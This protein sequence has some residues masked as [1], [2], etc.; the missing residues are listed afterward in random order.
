MVARFGVPSDL[1]SDCG[2]KITS[3]VWTQVFRSLGISPSTTTSFH[4]QSNGMIECFHRSLKTALRN[5][6]AGS[7]WFLHLPLVL[8]GLRSA[9]NGGHRVLRLRGCVRFLKSSWMVMSLRHLS[10]CRR[11][12]WL[13]LDSPA[14][15][16]HHVSPAQPAP[17]PPALLAAKYILVREEASISTLAPL[18]VV[19]IWSWNGGL[20]SSAFT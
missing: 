12:S 15:P 20:N 6:L 18:F 10:S 7:D 11:L 3:S 13:S 9:S 8:L 1:T 5:C 19:L 17:L 14:P 16:P 4:P 2:T